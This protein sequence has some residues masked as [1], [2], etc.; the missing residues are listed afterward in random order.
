MREKV[1]SLDL[2]GD[3]LYDFFERNSFYADV[4][5]HNNHLK[6]GFNVF[7]RKFAHSGEIQCQSN[8]KIENCYE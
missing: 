4:V 3:G 8:T 1:L 7:S 6:C 2:N 5:E